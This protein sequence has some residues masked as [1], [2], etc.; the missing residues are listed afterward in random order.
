MTDSA[1]MN[2]IDNTARGALVPALERLSTLVRRPLDSGLAKVLLLAIGLQ[3]SALI[4]R[5]QLG[6]GPA[7]GLWQ[8]EPGSARKG[9]GVWG[10]FTHKASRELVL[11]WCLECGVLCSPA[12]IYKA[13]EHDDVFAAGIAR[14]L[15]WTDAV[16]LPRN[17]SAAWGMYAKRLWRPGKP[18]PEKWPLCWAAAVRYGIEQGW[19]ELDE[20]GAIK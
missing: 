14:L 18:H 3:E 6:G 8:F 13:I 20:S 5:R 4:H 1:T 12:E 17:R 11:A 15:M 10:V 7:R 16:A 9:G 19:V 2:L